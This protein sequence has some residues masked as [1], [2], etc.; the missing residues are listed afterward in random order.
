MGSLTMKN[1]PKEILGNQNMNLTDLVVK[2][3]GLIGSGRV[4]SD[5]ETTD[6]HTYPY[7]I[8]ARTPPPIF[9]LSCIFKSAPV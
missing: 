3:M 2:K 6:I 7:K 1:G 8:M 4:K 5:P 9:S